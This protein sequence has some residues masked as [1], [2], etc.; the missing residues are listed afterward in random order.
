MPTKEIDARSYKDG[1][2]FYK[3][4]QDETE[5]WGV[6]NTNGEILVPA[7]YEAIEFYTNEGV[8]GA[9]DAT[10]WRIINTKAQSSFF[11]N[12]INLVPNPLAHTKSPVTLLK[13]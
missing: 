5:L 11:F 13:F 10:G 12:V 6:K 2:Y 1:T 3:A 7:Q 4:Y 8:I 9:K